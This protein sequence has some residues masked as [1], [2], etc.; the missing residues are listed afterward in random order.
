MNANALLTKE[1]EWVKSEA[2]DA[3]LLVTAAPESIKL[4]QLVKRSIEETPLRLSGSHHECRTGHIGINLLD[5]E[6][7]RS[8]ALILVGTLARHLLLPFLLTFQILR[9]PLSDILH[10]ILNRLIHRRF[11]CTRTSQQ[12]RRQCS[13]MYYI[14]NISEARLP[15]MRSERRKD[16]VRH[17]R[18]INLRCPRYQQFHQLRQF[19]RH[20]WRFGIIL[21]GTLNSVTLNLEH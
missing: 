6:I 9:I 2:H 16:S 12:A 11:T 21:L 7:I 4:V 18:L 10:D 1:V 14:I 8:F 19:L 3:E 5:N 15:E 13:F 17:S 20:R